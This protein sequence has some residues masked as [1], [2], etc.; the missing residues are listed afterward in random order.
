M[1]MGLV[2]KLGALAGAG[3]GSYVG[4]KVGKA[5]GGKKGKNV[6]NYVGA[7]VGAH[8]AGGAARMIPVIGSFKKGGKVRRTGAY[9]LHKG[10]YVVPVRKKHRKK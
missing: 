9:L 4:K 3:A 8:L 7:V 5:V 6:G 2:T 10:E 1:V